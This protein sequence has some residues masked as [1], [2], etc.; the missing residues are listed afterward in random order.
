MVKFRGIEAA[1]H[2][3]PPGGKVGRDGEASSLSGRGGTSAIME[4]GL[5]G[6]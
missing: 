3:A 6:D 4:S 5:S 2:Q 1:L